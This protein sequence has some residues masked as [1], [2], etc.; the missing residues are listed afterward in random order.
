MRT[1]YP[2]RS[3]RPV[4]PKRLQPQRLQVRLGAFVVRGDGTMAVLAAAI[5]ALALIALSLT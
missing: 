3:R 5:V 2:L 1:P 4:S